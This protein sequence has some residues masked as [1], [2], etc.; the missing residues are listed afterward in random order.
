MT[1]AVSA[2][3]ATPAAAGSAPVLKV[4]GLSKAFPG[5]QAL[6]D[7]DFD[8]RPGEVHCL[9][10]E[11]GAGKSTLVK[12]LAGVQTA[13]EGEILI[14]GSPVAFSSPLAAQEAGIACIFQEL[15]VVGGLTVAENIMLGAEPGRFGFVDRNSNEA[16]SRAL[17]DSVGFPELDVSRPCRELSPA[18]KQAVMIAKALRQN[19]RVI[20]MDEPSSPL[21][22]LEVRRLFE[23]IAR[24]KA[25]GK[26]II[27]VSHK[28][29]EIAELGDRITVFKD[30]A[31]VATLDRGEA[32]SGELVRL[33][34]GR[35]LKE[36]FPPNNR[37]PGDVI[38]DVAGLTGERVRDVSFQL[39]AGEILGIAGS[40]RRRPHRAAPDHLRRRRAPR[41]RGDARRRAGAGELGAG[42][43]RRRARARPGRAAHPGHR[44]RPQRRRQCQLR[45]GRVPR[46]T[47]QPAVPSRRGAVDREYA[48]CAD[49]GTGTA[50]RR[51]LRWQSAK[52]RLRQMADAEHAGAAPRRADPRHRCRR[53]AGNLPHRFRSRRARPRDHP[54][55]IGTARAARSRRPA[56]RAQPWRRRRGTA[57]K[58]DGGGGHRAVDA[59]R[60]FAASR[61]RLPVSKTCGGIE[62]CW[63]RT[64]ARWRP[65]AEP[66][67]RSQGRG[68]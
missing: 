10:G 49:A 20:I 18:E 16:R 22:E 1:A 38:L 59:A 2:G 21:E 17:L 66:R 6:R 62:R 28:M 30:G 23:V 24:L 46:A 19:A 29:R 40:G 60:A 39:R 5:V 67:G 26:A 61:R 35:Q 33:M 9:I 8:L 7:I 57:G 53:Q 47:R 32:D 4:A 41:R 63:I 3:E 54:G 12:I 55:V 44:P 27:Y 37:S 64:A 50:H 15:N 14:A 43:D 48:E 68:P 11:N 13:D 52:G 56:D 45:V 31:R 51:A 65:R 58:R 25:A 34:V 36:M 42:G